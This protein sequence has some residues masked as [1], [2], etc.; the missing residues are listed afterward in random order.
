[1][2]GDEMT[3][4]EKPHSVPGTTRRNRLVAGRLPALLLVSALFALLLSRGPSLVAV[5]QRNLSNRPYLVAAMSGPGL[6][7]A[8]PT[9]AN[10]F[11]ARAQALMAR[12]Q[13][14]PVEAEQW[15]LSGLTGAD[16]DELTRFEACRQ[17]MKQGRLAE[18]KNLC[19]DVAPTTPYWLAQGIAADESGRI[20][21]AILYFDLARTADSKLLVAWER[22]GR[23][24]FRAQRPAEVVAVYE[25]L[26]SVQP[27]PLADTYYQ[28]GK[29]YMA[30]GQLDEARAALQR[31]LEQYPFQRDF[32]LALAEI[33]L[34]AGQLDEADAWYARLLR[35]QPDDAY[36]WAQRGEVAFKSGRAEAAL[37]YL[38]QATAL[39]P[40]AVGYWLSL[41]AVAA[42]AGEFERAATAY[43]RSLTLRPQDVG[44]LLEAARFFAQSGHASQARA[45]Y[46]RVLSLEPTNSTA[47]EALVT[48]ATGSAAP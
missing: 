42:S 5:V 4:A 41:A 30:L 24:N 39:E 14:R 43:K 10:A 31:G 40:T 22:L 8:L 19:R 28:L 44:T 17:L 46:E 37:V 23:A 45:L 11:Q 26:L 1:M 34:A 33:A 3:P 48:P 29:A 36:A 9:P 15:L 6:I 16:G 12:E 7:A 25:H 13:G 20:D 47:L 27:Q 38:E 18:A 21:E 32:P 35:E 2:K